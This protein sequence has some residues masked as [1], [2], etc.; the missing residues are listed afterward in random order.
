MNE[1]MHIGQWLNDADKIL[2]NKPELLTLFDHKF[3]M[4]WSKI[5]TEI[6]R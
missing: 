1:L 6:S 5:E 2:G 4:N 3:H